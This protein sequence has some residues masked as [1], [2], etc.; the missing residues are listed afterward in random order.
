MSVSRPSGLSGRLWRRSSECHQ[1]CR[2][3]Q[4]VGRRFPQDLGQI[5]AGHVALFLEPSSVVMVAS[6]NGLLSMVEAAAGAV[7]HEVDL[8]DDLCQP[9]AFSPDGEYLV[10][11]RGDG[12]FTVR[13][14]VTGVTMQTLHMGHPADVTSV[15]YAPSGQHIAIGNSS[16]NLLFLELAP[17]GFV[18]GDTSPSL[19]LDHVSR[20]L[21]E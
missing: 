1:L 16:G 8:G 21:A 14:T 6:S 13:E 4:D 7:L 15:A 12:C 5:L 2:L 11:E 9:I 18:L 3:I 19:A 17:E 20:V 10:H